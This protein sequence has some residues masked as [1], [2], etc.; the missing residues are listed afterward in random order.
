[1]ESLTRI[2]L[3]PV[4]T[5]FPL[6]FMA[7]AGATVVLAGLQLGWLPVAESKQVSL[8]LIVFAFPLQ[9]TASVIGFLSRDTSAGSGLGLLAGSWLTIGILLLTSPPGSRS[10]TLALFLFVAGGA[11]LVPATAAALGKIVVALVLALTA[12]RYVVTGVYELQ[13]GV[14][15]EHA[16]GWLGVA[17]CVVALYAALALEIE[18]MQHHTVLPVLRRGKGRQVMTGGV[19]DEIQRVER[20]A[21]VR[22]Q[23]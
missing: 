7:L 6:G 22:E 14:G 16:A 3:R 18:D 4:G 12:A 23:L 15:W 10:A 8:L 2:F 13:G 19:L 21:G 17:L 20:E 5:P 11:L 1:M 9:L